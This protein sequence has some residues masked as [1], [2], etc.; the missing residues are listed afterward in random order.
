M[1]YVPPVED[2]PEKKKRPLEVR[3]DSYPRRPKP[4]DLSK[5]PLDLEV[6]LPR[7]AMQRATNRRNLQC[8]KKTTA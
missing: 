5:L 1:I 2:I 4:V 8:K 3:A 7:L 6:V